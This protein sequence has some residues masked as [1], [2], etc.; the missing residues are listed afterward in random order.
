MWEY[1]EEGIIHFY[2]MML[3]KDEVNETLS[4]LLVHSGM[5]ITFFSVVHWRNE[6]RWD[7]PFH[8]SLLWSKLLRRKVDDWAVG[9]LSNRAIKKDEELTFNYI[10]DRYG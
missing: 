2:F 10:V 7:W 3:Q 5:Q 6:A 4:V 8:K 9:I 1:A